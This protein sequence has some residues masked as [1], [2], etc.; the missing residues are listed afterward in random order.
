MRRGSGAGGPRSGPW[1]GGACCVVRPCAGGECQALRAV[2]PCAPRGPAR[3]AWF[4]PGP[5]WGG[6]LARW[7]VP[8]GSGR[9]DAA[10]PPARAGPG[11]SPP[12]RM[13]R[14][15]GAGG[16]RSGPWS[17]GAC[18]VVRALRAVRPCAGG[19][20][21]ALRAARSWACCGFGRGRAPVRAPVLALGRPVPRC[22][23]PA[24]AA[25]S[26]RGRARGR[27]P[28]RG[29]APAGAARVRPVL[30]A[31]ALPLGCP[32]VFG[33]RRA[34]AVTKSISSSTRPSSAGSRS[35]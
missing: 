26:G 15:S 27:A 4:G 30:A 9:A 16:P 31:R 5:V 18:C 33:P 22:S 7:R 12:L 14:G 3:A 29:P 2:R 6:A 25:R 32:A 34:Q 20:C 10:R 19:E 23:G 24:H 28:S 13:R 11:P 8:R 17:G 35:L 1:P 21:R